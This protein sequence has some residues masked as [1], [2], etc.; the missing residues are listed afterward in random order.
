MNNY[1]SNLQEFQAWSKKIEE[2]ASLDPERPIPKSVT[3]LPV[4][5]SPLT[6]AERQWAEYVVDRLKTIGS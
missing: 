2:L 4:V 1:W 5:Q 6:E 3:C